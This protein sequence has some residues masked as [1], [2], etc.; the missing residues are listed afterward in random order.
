MKKFP[1]MISILTLSL[2]LFSCK[3]SSQKDCEKNNTGSIMFHN[4]VSGSA[5][6]I[7]IYS[8]TTYLGFVKKNDMLTVN[9]ITV[10]K[11]VFTFK[12]YGYSGSW[13]S[14]SIVVTQCNVS[15]FSIP[16]P[17]ISDKRLKKNIL[18]LNNALEELN[19]LNIYS[20]EYKATKDYSGYLP[21]G[22]HFGFLAQ[23]LKDV[24][25]T[26]VNLNNNGYYSVNY[27]EMIPILAK[28]I[29]E[30]QTQIDQLKK[31]VDELKGLIR[32][33]QPVAVK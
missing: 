18:P 27:Q 5:D 31:E 1:L 26:F 24:Y 16:L 17:P 21:S 19:K 33:Q 25:P 7:E 2:I 28:G 29:K 4:D 9:N 15:H 22:R 3:K 12:V 10:G 11:N 8:D 20:Y 30:Q 13:P 23:E 14:D 6:T 32:S